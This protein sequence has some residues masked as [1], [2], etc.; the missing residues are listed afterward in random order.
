M[1]RFILQFA[2]HISI[3]INYI[4]LTFREILRVASSL[5]VCWIRLI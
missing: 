1:V 4:L 2:G 3:A 5:L